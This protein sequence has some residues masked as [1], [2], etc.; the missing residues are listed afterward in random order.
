MFFRVKAQFDLMVENRPE[1]Q[2]YWFDWMY[3]F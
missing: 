2:R 1:T 3:A